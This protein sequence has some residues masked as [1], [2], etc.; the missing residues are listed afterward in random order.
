MTKEIVRYP[1]KANIEFNAPVRFFNDELKELIQDLK[2]TII[3]NN[4]QGL[5]GYQINNPYSVVV[6]KNDNGTFLELIN[7]RIIKSNGKITTKEKTTYF[8]DIEVEIT[9]DKNITVMYEDVDAKQCY[10]DVSDEKAVLLQRKIDY[11]FGANFYQ[12][13]DKNQQ[14]QLENNLSAGIGVVIN[15][16]CPTNFKRDKILKIT[17]IVL[18]IL[19]LSSIFNIFK[20]Y[21]SYGFFTTTILIITYFFYAQYEGKKFSNCTS[22]Q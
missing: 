19:L 21:L 4:L 3:E 16:S 14:D 9:R 15:N 10:I 17:N 20:E 11:T 22:C 2:D 18:L 13:L 8:N 1:S 7:P 12:R 6:I 5:S